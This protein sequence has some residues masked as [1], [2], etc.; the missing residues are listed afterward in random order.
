MEERWL[1]SQPGT[2]RTH[3]SP[4]DAGRCRDRSTWRCR[5]TAP[6]LRT[7][8][9]L[10]IDDTFGGDNDLPNAAETLLAALAGWYASTLRMV[11]DQL[12]VSIESL[13]VIAHGSVDARGAPGNGPGRHRRVLITIARDP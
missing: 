3:Q 4:E 13:D 10:G 6:T 9:A 12:A 7:A 8:W 2:S 1:P 5:W 11:A